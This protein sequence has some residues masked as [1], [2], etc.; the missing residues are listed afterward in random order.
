MGRI[1]SVVASLLEGSKK[2]TTGTGTRRR[3]GGNRYK[4]GLPQNSPKSSS[5]SIMPQSNIWP[6]SC[7]A[8]KH[9]AIDEY[10]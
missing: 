4:D 7:A 8:I 5:L 6:R 9:Y 10:A 1:E 3:S 2:K